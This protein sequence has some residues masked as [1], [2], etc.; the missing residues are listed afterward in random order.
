MYLYRDQILILK[1]HTNYLNDLQNKIWMDSV[2]Y[3]KQ[4][5]PN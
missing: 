1:K 2:L 3:V 4:F 5:N